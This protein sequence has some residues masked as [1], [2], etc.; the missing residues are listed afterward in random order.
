[1]K[2]NHKYGIEEVERRC[3]GELKTQLNELARRVESRTG[4]ICENVDE[5]DCFNLFSTRDEVLCLHL[6]GA[7]KTLKERIGK[8]TS[9]EELVGM[10][11]NTLEW[12][13]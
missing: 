8:M 2:L 5:A 6:N 7:N 12:S 4:E 9:E 1:M 13:S 10:L 3:I 11:M